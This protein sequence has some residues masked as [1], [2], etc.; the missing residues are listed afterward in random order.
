VGDRTIIAAQSGVT[1]SLPSSGVFWG[2]PARPLNETKE[3]LVLLNQLK[4]MKKKLSNLEKKI[5][6]D[7]KK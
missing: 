5:N 7:N 2:T 3:Q 4:D 1:K 6:M